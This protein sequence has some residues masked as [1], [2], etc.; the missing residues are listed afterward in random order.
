MKA[1]G[2]TVLAAVMAIGF[3]GSQYSQTTGVLSGQAAGGDSAGC[4]GDT[5][6]DEDLQALVGSD[7]I[8]DDDASTLR[9]ADVQEERSIELVGH[10]MNETRFTTS[11]W[12]L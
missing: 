1:H 2:F 8:T 7:E 4:G 9:E 10:M 12:S 5:Y 11:G 3:A 6:Y